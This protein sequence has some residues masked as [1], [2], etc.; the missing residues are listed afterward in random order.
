MPV[1]EEPG[2]DDEHLGDLEAVTD[3][4]LGQVDVESLLNTLLDRVREILSA[5]TAAVL[6]LDESG[7]YLVATAARGIEAEV[8]QGVRIPLGTG[9]AGRIARDRRPATLD[10]VDRTTVYNPILWEHGIKAML[11]VPLMAGGN[12]IGV[13]H[14]GSREIRSFTPEDTR[15]LE[16]AADRIAL[17]TL[18]RVVEAERAAAHV[19]QRSLLPS[20]LPEL[21]GIELAARYVP[22]S[23]GGVGGDWYDVFWLPSGELCMVIGDVAGH[24][25]RAAVV[26]GRVRS[27]LRAYALEND[28]PETILELVDRKLQYFE[29]GHMVTALCVI[30]D[31]EL[32]NVTIASAGHPPPVLAT[33]GGPGALVDIAIDPPLGISQGIR[34]TATTITLDAGD[35]LLLY[36]DGLYER[37]GTDVDARLALLESAVR[38]APAEFVCASVMRRMIGEDPTEDDVAVLALYRVHNV[39]D[40]RPA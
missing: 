23:R 7:R 9:F 22:A 5:D 35:V 33:G 28:R 21:P 3:A 1:A 16:L 8:H 27:A 38:P 11:G 10:R 24:G 18:S 4:A 32:E 6:L 19:L 13:L 25:V 14:V 36:T 15:L 39:A 29:A 20:A 12:V 31:A 37:R 17:A 34:R 26:M 2:T 40:S 30:A